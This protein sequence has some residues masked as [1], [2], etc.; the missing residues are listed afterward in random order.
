MVNSTR[1]KPA[2]EQVAQA[3]AARPL[4]ASG[5]ARAQEKARQSSKIKEVGDCLLATGFLT[6]EQQ[7][8]AL[9]LARSTTWTILRA[10]HKNSGLSAAIIARMLSTPRLPPLVRVKIF[11]YVNEKAAGSYGHSKIQ[12][13]RFIARL[14]IK[15]V[16]PC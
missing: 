1:I 9:G 2:L 10:N 14:P 3:F 6:L 15:P 13:Q 4:F 7:A 11:E 5:K 16:E 8:D 12:R